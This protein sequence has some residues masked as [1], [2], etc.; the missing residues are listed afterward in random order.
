HS[1]LRD[2]LRDRLGGDRLGHR[3]PDRQV[4]RGAARDAA[5]RNRGSRHRRARRARLQLLTSL[6][7]SGTAPLP[8]VPPPRVPPANATSRAGAYAPALF[9]LAAAGADG[10]KRLISRSR[11]VAIEQH[12]RPKRSPRRRLLSSLSLA[13][14]RK[15]RENLAGLDC[16]NGSCCLR[17]AVR[18]SLVARK[19][20]CNYKAGAQVQR[21]SNMRKIVLGMA[22]AATAIAVPALARDGQGYFGADIG[23]II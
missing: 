7:G 23:M 14:E 12:F 18:L 19:R 4:H 21:G 10:L 16:T 22:V 13:L 1:A 3:V 20:S 5:S 8:S 15:V 2:R 17:L 6:A 11:G 9:L